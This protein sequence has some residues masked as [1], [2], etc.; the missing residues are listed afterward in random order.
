[1]IFSWK[2]F[3][4]AAVLGIVLLGISIDPE[5]PRLALEFDYG[6]FLDSHTWTVSLTVLIGIGLVIGLMNFTRRGN[7]DED[8]GSPSDPGR[9]GGSHPFNK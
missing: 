2:F 1:M 3:G 8:Q 7:R 4:A 5:L 6:K 9:Y